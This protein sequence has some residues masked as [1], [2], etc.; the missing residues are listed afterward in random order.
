MTGSLS[1][2]PGPVRR[3]PT[4]LPSLHDVDHDTTPRSAFHQLMRGGD[5]IERESGHNVRAQPPVQERAG[6]RA[7][8]RGLGRGR[9]IPLKGLK[10]DDLFSDLIRDGSG[11]ATMWVQGKSERIEVSFGPNY[12]AAVVWF[13]AG[14]TQNFICFEPMAGIT[15]GMNLA[16]KG[17][18]KELQSIPP[19]QSWQESFWVKPSG[20]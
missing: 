8:G 17:V 7:G 6:H 1:G 5:L 14:P 13:P 4:W 2:R 11:R 20:F 12:K 10:L 9:K 15:D 3:P 19:G 18:Y 16:Q